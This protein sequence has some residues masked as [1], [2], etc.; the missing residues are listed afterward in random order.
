M[1]NETINLMVFHGSRKPEANKHAIAFGE[2]LK[3]SYPQEFHSK[4]C[5]LD[6]IEPTLNKIRDS[7]FNKIR[8]IPMFLLPGSHYVNDI[9]QLT[10]K[11]K[12]NNSNL[13]IE[14]CN[15]LVEMPDFVGFIRNQMK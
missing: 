11:F 12:R 14:I 4:V 10:D 3:E 7:G 15:C 1:Q 6:S 8:I 5:F 2:S 9:I 13:Q